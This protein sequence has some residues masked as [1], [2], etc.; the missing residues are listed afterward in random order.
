VDSKLKRTV[1]VHA[2]EVSL[3]LQYHE[4]KLTSLLS[5]QPTISPFKAKRQV[6]KIS[7][8]AFLQNE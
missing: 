3:L 7:S 4:N 2:I 1:R 6:K 5:R 8:T